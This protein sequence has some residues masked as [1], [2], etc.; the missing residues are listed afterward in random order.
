MSQI[1]GGKISPM[2]L[3]ALVALTRIVTMTIAFPMVTSSGVGR[4]GWIASLISGSLALLF[5][6]GVASLGLRFPDK[7]IF[8]YSEILLGKVLGKL[9][10]LIL[11]WYFFH[12]AVNV[13]RA[14]AESFAI[15]ILDHTPILVT[16]L[17]FL[18]LSMNSARNGLEVI[19]RMAENA[20]FVVL[21]FVLITVILPYDNMD[22]ARLLP[23]LANGFAPVIASSMIS[24]GLYTELI[25]FGVVIPYLNKPSEAKRAL[26]RGVMLGVLVMTILCVVLT[27]VFGPTLTSLSLP[28]FSLGRM[29]SITQFLERIEIF[30]IG[31]WTL[32]TGIRLSLLCWV[33]LIGIA[34]I[35]GLSDYK[36]IAYPVAALILVGS[37]LFYESNFALEKFFMADLFGVYSIGIVLIPFILLFSVALIRK[38]TSK[39][40]ME[41]ERQ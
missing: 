25:V 34:Q 39:S 30:P 36:P 3:S 12:D 37:L 14:F 21:F 33:L 24:F 7:T 19:G 1:E 32:A 38:G 23:I 16:M 17:M 22:F 20:L 27:S 35:V 10:S 31:A 5:G 41:E 18:F 2:Q 4:D 28:T 6:Y 9:I 8:E 11:L 40:S 29:I 26:S 15:S 13:T